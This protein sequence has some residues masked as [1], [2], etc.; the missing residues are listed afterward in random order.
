MNRALFSIFGLLLL[1]LSV[2]AAGA[3][4]G[5]GE[6]CGCD[7]PPARRAAYDAV[8]MAADA[9]ESATQHAPYGVAVAKA[10][11]LPPIVLAQP[12]WLTG[13]DPVRRMP[14]WVA[15]RLSAADVAVKRKR[16]QCFRP[17][18]R[19]PAAMGGT[20]CASYRGDGMDRG[21]MVASADMTRSE[22]AMVNTYVFSNIAHQYP[23]FNR[24][25]WRD[26]EI[27]VRAMA[28]LRGEIYV[29]SGAVF[30]HDADGR[31]DAPATAPHPTKSGRPAAAVA[32]HFY[33]IVIVPQA[34]TGA[35]EVVAWL[36]RHENIKTTRAES[37]RRIAAQR[38]PL[39]TV[40]RLSGLDI[41][42]ALNG[43][44]TAGVVSD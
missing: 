1:L 42:P 7:V 25:L 34:G 37:K 27:R 10:P 22:Q 33:K 30:D 5:A 35:P 16:T 21:H 9:V 31:P 39:E 23:A 8:L 12:H 3:G 36:L 26:L 19:V 20:R 4:T 17:D 6:T 13:Y 32:S 41:A 15:Y 24:T 38:V 11:S 29:M 14:L 44:R 40:E 43:I 18:P 28:R 2:P